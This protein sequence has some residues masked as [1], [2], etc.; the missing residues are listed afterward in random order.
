MGY[1][2]VNS[3]TGA[4]VYCRS[5]SKMGVLVGSTR[6]TINKFFGQGKDSSLILILNDWH[7]SRTSKGSDGKIF[8]F[9]G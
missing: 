3:I 5:S 8:T 1:I 6:H 4:K 2:G 7:I 9:G